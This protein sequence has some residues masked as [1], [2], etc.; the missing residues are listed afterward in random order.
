MTAALVAFGA[1]L[2]DPAR[3][4]AEVAER[5]RKSAGVE[6]VNASSLHRTAPVGGPPDQPEF[7]NG[8][9]AVKTTLDIEAFFSAMRAVEA[10]LGRER[11][12]AWGPRTID[13]DLVSFG[14]IVRSSAS[15]TT[16]H[17]RM[18][19]RRFVLVPAAEVA[20]EAVH[21]LLDMSVRDLETT[22]REIACGETLLA[23]VGDHRDERSAAANSFRSRFPKGR[24]VGLPL[25]ALPGAAI[26]HAGSIVGIRPAVH[27][28]GVEDDELERNLDLVWEAANSGRLWVASAATIQQGP[29]APG[30]RIVPTVDVRGAEAELRA[31]EFAN[32]LGG[33]APL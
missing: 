20:P 25:D 5:L 21:P 4:F 33:L 3:M 23:Y 17:P 31:K 9:F 22:T 30:M 1:N 32:F 27:L 16:P 13:L 10:D 26:T 18:H 2:G 15:L 14:S 7:F 19:Y 11:K 6:T 28:P 29:H 12:E 24:F 8:A